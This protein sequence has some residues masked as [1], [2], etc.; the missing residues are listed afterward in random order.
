MSHLVRANCKGKVS[1]YQSFIFPLFLISFQ[2]A[3][4]KN[5]VTGRI[6]VD[7]CGLLVI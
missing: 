3:Q 1:L 2:Q 6:R 4:Y 5:H 7:L